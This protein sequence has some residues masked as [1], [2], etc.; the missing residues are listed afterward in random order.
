MEEAHVVPTG[1]I[2]QNYKHTNIW[3]MHTWSET[4]PVVG[5]RKKLHCQETHKQQKK[6]GKLHSCYAA[7][8]NHPRDRKVWLV[9]PRRKETQVYLA[10]VWVQQ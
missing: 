3:S 8:R 9:L 7:G 6:E 2:K 10:I 4:A 1:N 5:S